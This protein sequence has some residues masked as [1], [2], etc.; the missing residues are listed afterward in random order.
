MAVMWTPNL[1]YYNFNC[2]YVISPSLSVWKTLRNTFFQYL[3]QRNFKLRFQRG[4]GI[5]TGLPHALINSNL[6]VFN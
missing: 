4:G 6:V 1:S 3:E 5:E 2:T